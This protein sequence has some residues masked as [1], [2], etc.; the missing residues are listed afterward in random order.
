MTVEGWAVVLTL[1]G[2]FTVHIF[3]FG[4]GLGEM[5]ATVNHL[6]SSFDDFKAQHYVS[7]DEYESRHKDL[8]E[9]VGRLTDPARSK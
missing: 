7:R 1:V 6:A 5:K 8:V 2:G 9:L 4:R 3:Y